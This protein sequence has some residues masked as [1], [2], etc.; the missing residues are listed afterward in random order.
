[1]LKHIVLVLNSRGQEI[2]HVLLDVNMCIQIKKRV[3]IWTKT[4][5]LADFGKK[6]CVDILAI[7][8]ISS[9]R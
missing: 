9:D 6:N 1:M 3:Q 7:T 5:F 2:L 8:M 4:L